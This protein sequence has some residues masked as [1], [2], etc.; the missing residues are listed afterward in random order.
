MINDKNATVRNFRTTERMDT[1]NKILNMSN[2]TFNLFLAFLQKEL[3][4]EENA[5]NPC[6][7]D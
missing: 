2:E 7:T 6:Q 3:K 4:S 5:D 1:I